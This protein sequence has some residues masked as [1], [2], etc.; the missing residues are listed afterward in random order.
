MRAGLLAAD[1]PRAQR[2]RGVVQ[3]AQPRQEHIAL[4]HQRRGI[5]PDRAAIGLL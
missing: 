4:G 5:G 1:P 2:K 3:R